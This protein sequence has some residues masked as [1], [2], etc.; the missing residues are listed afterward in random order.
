MRRCECSTRPSS[1]GH[2]RCL[3][4]AVAVPIVTP[5]S[6]LAT[7]APR[8]SKL[9]ARTVAPVERREPVRGQ[10]ER[11]SLGHPS[12]TC[13]A[14]STS[15]RGPCSKP[16]AR[17]AGST[18]LVS[19]LSPSSRSIVSRLGRPSRTCAASAASAGPG[20][21]IAA[22]DSVSSE[23][24][25]RSTY[26]SGSPSRSTTY[27]PT[28]RAA[29]PAARRGQGSV[30][31]YRFAGSVA[32]STR[33]DGLER[34]LARVAQ[35]LDRA[36]QRELRAAAAV[37][38]PAAPAGAE[39]LEVRERAVHAREA[40]RHLL[41]DHRAARQHAVALEQQLGDR[42]RAIARRRRRPRTG[43]AVEDQRP[44]AAPAGALRRRASRRP[45]TR[46]DLARGR[47][48]CASR[49]AARRRRS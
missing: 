32:A 13:G 44:S 28:A 43:R 26:S 40:A 2:S 20:F 5:S 14:R 29:R 1:V 16:A 27:A 49:A 30:A 17:N 35:P 10:H 11:V 39:R 47:R 4:R 37:D 25:P 6:A 12:P 3:P 8:G 46:D 41:G 36:R 22:S 33:E 21:S 31:P 18:A 15:R 23:R 9:S 24:P 19:A 7:A 38:E 42:A 34:R 48:A 45:A